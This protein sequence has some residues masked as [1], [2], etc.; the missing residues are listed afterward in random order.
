MFL[1]Y[2]KIIFFNSLSKVMLN[3]EKSHFLSRFLFFLSLFFATNNMRFLYF[4]V[5]YIGILQIL[6]AHMVF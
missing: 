4:S 6:S 3:L 5:M 2:R 1:T